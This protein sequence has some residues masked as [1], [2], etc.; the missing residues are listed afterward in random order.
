LTAEQQSSIQEARQQILK[1]RRE[2]RGVQHNLN[3]DI[4][5]LETRLKFANIG[6]MPI[7]I[8]VIAVIIAL[9]RHRRRRRRAETELS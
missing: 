5:R 9:L 1:T 2:L 8:A 4:E 6:L 3:R 7:A